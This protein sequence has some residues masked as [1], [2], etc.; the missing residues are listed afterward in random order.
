MQA[1]QLSRPP[2]TT[3]HADPFL[4]SGASELPAAVAGARGR[5]W[6]A[7]EQLCAHLAAQSAA[8][9]LATA[10]REWWA[11][12]GRTA[13]VP[14]TLGLPGSRRVRQVLTRWEAHA[15]AC[16]CLCGG[17]SGLEQSWHH[18]GPPLFSRHTPSYLSRPTWN[19]YGIM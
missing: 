4:A 19:R 10:G 9:P 11:A 13:F 1:L 6:A 14:A 5:V 12:L 16:V 15:G 8:P 3:H 7:A 2:L 18:A 17:V